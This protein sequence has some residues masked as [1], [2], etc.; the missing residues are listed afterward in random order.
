MIVS[1]VQ[2]LENF[3]QELL[4]TDS[5]MYTIWLWSDQVDLCDSTYAI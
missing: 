4:T 1:S 5:K 2:I 3:Q